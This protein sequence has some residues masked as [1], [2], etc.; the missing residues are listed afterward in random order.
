MGTPEMSAELLE[1]LAGK[2]LDIVGV[3]TSVDKPRGRSGKPSPSPVKAAAARLGIPVYQPRKMRLEWEFFKGISFDAVLTFAYGQIVPQEFL[4]LAPYG[5]YNF[6]GS[7]LPKYR[8]A[9]PIQRAIMA[10]ERETGVSLMKMV[11]A[12]DAG[13]VYAVKKIPIT[14]EDDYGTICGKMALAS[15]DLAAESLLGVINGENKGVPQDESLAT[16]AGKI[17]KEDERLPF[18][19]LSPVEAVNYVKALSPTPG[20]Y[21]AV[22][23][24]K[25]KVLKAALVD[26]AVPTGKLGICG[27]EPCLGVEGGAIALKEVELEGKKPTDGKSFLNGHRPMFQDA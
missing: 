12:M 14:E 2:G 8:G 25:L 23:G 1:V 10:G 11:A 22:G 26:A 16:I 7:I 19:R 9:A 6:H 17:K 27:K 24:K 15:A 20:A 18:E 5:N 13:E 21:L 3:V 4:D